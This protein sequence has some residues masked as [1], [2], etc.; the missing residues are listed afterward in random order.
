MRAIVFFALLIAHS[1]FAATIYVNQSAA[2]SNDGTTWANAYTD[3]NAAITASSFGDQLWVAAG[4]Y[5][6]TT[7]TNR[8][9]AFALKS[10]VAIYGGF[11]GTETLLN[12]RDFT[13]NVS[14]LSGD[15]GVSGVATDN[16]HHVVTA[17]N[18]N[19]LTRLDGFEITAGYCTSASTLISVGAGIFVEDASPTVS[20]CKIYNNYSASVG[21][22][23]SFRGTGI[24]TLS[25]SE[26][27]YNSANSG[28]GL[29]MLADNSATIFNVINC[30]ISNN[31]S[32]SDGGAVYYHEGTLNIDR[33]ILSGN[34]AGDTGGAIHAL[35]N[36]I[37]LN[38]YNSL[39]VGNKSSTNAAIITSTVSVSTSNIVNT[40]IADNNN[41]TSGSFNT[42]ALLNE[43]V[44]VKNCIIWG[45]GSATSL[46]AL[47]MGNQSVVTN[48]IIEGGFTYGTNIITTN[49]GFVSPGSTLLAPFDAAGYDY[50]LLATSLGID[51]GDNAAIFPLYQTD[52]DNNPR[53]FG[54]TVDIGAYEVNYCSLTANIT[55]AS[56]PSICPGASVSLTASGGTN[57]LWSGGQTTATVTANSATTYTVTVTDGSGCRGTASQVVAAL[58]SGVTIGG[59]LGFCA[60]D[61]TTL[62]ASGN[63]TSYAWSNGPTVAANTVTTAGSYTVTATSNDGCTATASATVVV[64][65]LPI[66]TIVKSGGD[67]SI[68]TTYPTIEWFL[69][70]TSE[71]TGPN[72]YTP[73]GAGTVTVEVTDANGC[74][75]TAS[76]VFTAIDAVELD[77]VNLYPN[78]VSNMLYVSTG[79]AQSTIVTLMDISGKVLHQQTTENGNS[80]ISMEQLSSGVY[81]VKVSSNNKTYR[82]IK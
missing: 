12:Q 47:A 4:T 39:I 63:N 68:S 18:V 26:V 28:A 21:G 2:G 25:N 71:Q 64:N 32:V 53:T 5:K 34:L 81:L 3:L 16:T 80:Q 15:I 24:F 7:T 69:D 43:D 37:V 46:S 78:P 58:S 41:T 23:I 55:P 75:G 36:S 66:P 17:V 61:S 74:S 62:T 67:Y 45:N 54:G 65:A 10:G 11:A 14:R 73:S 38:V 51:N 27:S 44:I 82:V 29:Y 48:S 72:L 60:G 35:S 19:N 56:T 9:I 52:L 70:G 42:V 20:N 13:I 31:S 59:T 49:P 22:G 30:N 76:I 50:H 1:S 77:V 40:V 8:N 6:P 33:C 79:S 57:Y